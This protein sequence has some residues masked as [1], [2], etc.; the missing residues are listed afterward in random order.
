MKM[1][2]IVFIF[3]PVYVEKKIDAPVRARADGEFKKVSR[4]L[5]AR[6][7]RAP[8]SDPP[9]WTWFIEN[10]RPSSLHSQ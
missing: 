9:F 8:R 6:R 10:P 7:Y 2:T 1:K 3:V 4:I 5:F